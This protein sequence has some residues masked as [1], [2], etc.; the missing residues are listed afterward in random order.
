MIER[1]AVSVCLSERER[2]RE[3]QRETDRQRERQRQRE[4]DRQTDREREG[5]EEEAEQKDK[6]FDTGKNAF[7]ITLN[8]DVI[9]IYYFD[10]YYFVSYYLLLII[11]SLS[12]HDNAKENLIL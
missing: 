1:D 3:R 5:G 4:G 8:G 11:T 12:T 2:E 10:C 6:L 7:V 9:N